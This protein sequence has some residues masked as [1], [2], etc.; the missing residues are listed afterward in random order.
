MKTKESERNI[1]KML[2]AQLRNCRSILVFR[3]NKEYK[4]RD[5]KDNAWKAA[6]QFLVV[7]LST[8]RDQAILWKAVKFSLLLSLKS[9]L[10]R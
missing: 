1:Y 8:I 2:N 5:R 9:S 7:F 3:G 6:R 10:Y 4:E